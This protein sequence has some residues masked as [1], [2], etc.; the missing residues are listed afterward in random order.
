VSTIEQTGQTPPRTAR[1]QQINQHTIKFTVGVIAIFLGPLTCSFAP[2]PP[3]TSI[4]ASYYAGGV[5]QSIF[6][7]FLFATAAFLLAYNGYSTTEL[8]L[9]KLAAIAALGVALFPCHCAEHPQ[10]VLGVHTFSA[11][12]MFLILTCFCYGFYRRAREKRQ[13]YASRRGRIY[14]VCGFLILLSLL[15]LAVDPL[16]GHFFSRID[17]SLVFDGE[18][19]SLAAF[20][21]SWLTASRTLPFLTRSSERYSLL[22]NSNDPI[23]P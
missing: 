13:K 3:L 14:A 20:G 16:T 23:E 8:I 5:S 4:S 11:T 2:P 19:V 22:A 17:K 10:L 12:I 18:F 1:H 9:S 7:G 21:V 15:I 6:V